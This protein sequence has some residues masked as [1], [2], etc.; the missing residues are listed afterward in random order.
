MAKIMKIQNRNSK[1]ESY[2]V[3][4]NE[5]ELTVYHLQGFYPTLNKT[6]GFLFRCLKC[7]DKTWTDNWSNQYFKIGCHKC[8]KE[9]RV[10]YEEYR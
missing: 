6:G 7:L 9:E 1:R 8:K 4:W 10:R 3:Q 5:A 2:A